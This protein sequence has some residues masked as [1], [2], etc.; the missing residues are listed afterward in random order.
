MQWPTRMVPKFSFE[1]VKNIWLTERLPTMPEQ[2]DQLILLLG[3][4]QPSNLL[5]FTLAKYQLDGEIGADIVEDLGLN[6]WRYAAD[7]LREQKLINYGDGSTNGDIWLMLTI[8]G[9]LKFE[10]LQR[11]ISDSR[12]A[13]M[14]MKFGDPEIDQIFREHLLP[15]VAQTGFE[16]ER[17]D[18][19]PKPGLIDARME[20]EIRAARFMIADLTDGN[21]GAYWE[22]GFAAGLGK[23]VFYTCRKEYFENESTHFDTNHHYTVLW[24]TQA[25]QPAMQELKAMIRRAFP[26]DA[27]LHDD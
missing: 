10:E 12:K 20:V 25:P 22:A 2:A 18:M 6:A 3:Q 16:L 21:R 23:S 7:Y 9:W 15:A 26:A 4:R 17:L 5:P 13:F 24:Q 27:K 19:N 11:T 8:P 1:S 14:A